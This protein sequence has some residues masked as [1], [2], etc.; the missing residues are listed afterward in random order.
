MPVYTILCLG[1]MRGIVRRHAS[2]I[3]SR[4][5]TMVWPLVNTGPQ[6]ENGRAKNWY[7][8]MLLAWVNAGPSN[9]RD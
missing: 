5:P 7:I 8:P 2:H 9:K 1:E 3:H 4:N 6:N